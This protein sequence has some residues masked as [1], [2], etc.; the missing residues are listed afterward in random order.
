[1]A[2]PMW[3]RIADDL[4]VKIEA[5][6]LGSGGKPLPSELE[7]RD[8][9]SA[10]RNTIRDAVKWL[11]TRG[12]VVTRPG[13]GTFVVQ[14]IDPFVTTLSTDFGAGP[15]AEEANY[16]SE[17]TAHSRIPEVSRPRIEIQ[18]ASSLIA[19]ELRVAP[20]TTVVSRHQERRI[21]GIPW[22][23]QTSFYPM[24]FVNRGATRLIQAEDIPVGIVAYIEENIGLK[25]V[26][27]RDRFVVRAPD[28]KESSFFGLPDDGRIAV[29]EIIR[30]GYDGTG[31]PFRVTV[32]TYPVDRN[33]FVMTAG[34]VPPDEPI[35]QV[36]S[37]DGGG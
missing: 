34:D 29:F 16:L 19:G 3:R 6:E 31:T 25:Q 22:S 12:L 15:K 28:S 7:L 9:Y 27:W 32:T 23:L 35:A 17:I 30:T 18:Q 24:E 13:Q 14:K 20:D 2:D 1:M 4:R 8:A 37:Q 21:D 10:S 5:G 36:S 26:G 33:Q 11:V